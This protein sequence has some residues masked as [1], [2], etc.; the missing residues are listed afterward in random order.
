MSIDADLSMTYLK[1]LLDKN[2]DDSHLPL[3]KSHRCHGGKRDRCFKNFDNLIKQQGR[4]RPARFDKPGEHQDLDHYT[5]VPLRFCPKAS[6]PA[7][8]KGKGIGHGLSNAN[9]IKVSD[10]DRAFC[11][12]GAFSTVYRVRLDPHQHTLMRVSCFDPSRPLLTLS[13]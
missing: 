7:S 9:E 1:K 8:A 10:Q 12:S 5:V 4:F 2:I 3:T 13:V 6:P 11:G